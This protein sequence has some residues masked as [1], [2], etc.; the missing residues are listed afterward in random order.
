MTKETEKLVDRILGTCIAATIFLPMLF[1][2]KTTSHYTTI[3]DVVRYEPRIELLTIPLV[4]IIL[5]IIHQIWKK[6]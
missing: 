5:F 4:F 2:R 6:D 3:P 1:C